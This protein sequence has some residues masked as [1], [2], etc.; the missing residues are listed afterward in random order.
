MAQDRR[1]E[2]TS[3]V[4]RVSFTSRRRVEPEGEPEIAPA[5]DLTAAP[6]LT[7]AQDLSPNSENEVPEPSR[8]AFGVELPAGRN[9]M[10]VAV[11]ALTQLIS[12]ADEQGV[13][14]ADQSVRD[15]IIQ[16]R[17]T[18]EGASV[19]LPEPLM[20]LIDSMLPTEPDPAQRKSRLKL[21]DR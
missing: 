8:V 7:A 16:L 2:I 6:G 12:I 15:A 20:E 14:A 21:V 10:V 13:D 4:I 17:H 19:I 11:A 18:L 3:T 5:P 9:D 1:E